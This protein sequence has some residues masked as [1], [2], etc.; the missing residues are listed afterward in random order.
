MVYWSTRSVIERRGSKDRVHPPMVL[1]LRYK[2]EPGSRKSEKNSEWKTGFLYFIADSGTQVHV[3]SR[4]VKTNGCHNSTA[5]AIPRRTPLLSTVGF[6][7]RRWF[8]PRSSYP[9]VLES[10]SN[11]SRRM[12]FYIFLFSFLDLVI[13]DRNVRCCNRRWFCHWTMLA[14]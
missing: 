9:V 12:R 14:C 2:H 11:L 10:A 1:P 3:Y 8:Y 13:L 4:V 6:T 5:T 7:T